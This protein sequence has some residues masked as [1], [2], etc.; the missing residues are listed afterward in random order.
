MNKTSSYFI[1]ILP[2]TDHERRYYG[3][4]DFILFYRHMLDILNGILKYR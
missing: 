2:Y 3:H 4:H 1:S